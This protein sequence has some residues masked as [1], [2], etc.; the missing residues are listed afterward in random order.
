MTCFHFFWR[1]SRG[2]VRK[3][4]S[5]VHGKCMNHAVF[6]SRCRGSVERLGNTDSSV[7]F[8]CFVLCLCERARIRAHDT[9]N[10]G[11]LEMLNYW[12]LFMV[13]D[14]R[15]KKNTRATRRS[16][17]NIWNTAASRGVLILPSFPYGSV[18]NSN[19][20]TRICI[21]WVPWGSGVVTMPFKMSDVTMEIK[22]L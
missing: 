10:R 16:R 18:T 22:M 8:A 20:G 19:T 7:L 15:G 12:K 3:N 11:E 4:K 5:C 2:Y 1:H 21:C 13:R 14:G 9:Q 6:G 17:A